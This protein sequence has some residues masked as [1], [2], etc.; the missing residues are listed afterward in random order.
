VSRDRWEKE[1][2]KVQGARRK[3]L[4]CDWGNKGADAGF[5][6]SGNVEDVYKLS[7]LI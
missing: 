5:C 3:G 7:F 1:R 2:F 6:I 4:G